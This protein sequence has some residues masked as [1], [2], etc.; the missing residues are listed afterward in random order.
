[1]IARKVTKEETM[2]RFRLQFRPVPVADILRTD[3]PLEY[4][5]DTRRN[6]T[7]VMRTELHRWRQL[8]HHLA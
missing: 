2:K 6:V 5:Q 7:R 3:K 8:K 1:V 4:E